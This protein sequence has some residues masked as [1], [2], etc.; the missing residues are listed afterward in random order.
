MLDQRKSTIGVFIDLKKAFD[1]INHDILLK[2]LEFY[3]VRGIVNDWLYSYLNNRK[4]LVLLD[5]TKSNLLDVICGVPQGSILGPKLFILYIND[6]VQVSDL[7]KLIIFADDTNAFYSGEN[8]R[9]VANTVSSELNKLKIWFG[10]N[11]LSLNVSKTNYMV[12]TNSKIPPN[13]DISIQDYIIEKVNVTKFLG[14][15]IDEKLNWK[16]HI[17]MVKRN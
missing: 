8:I 17:E 1:T 16:Q 15:L 6:I 7:L 11:K 9:N 14:V 4:Q 10:V 5:N 2:K 3:G 12:F 13:I